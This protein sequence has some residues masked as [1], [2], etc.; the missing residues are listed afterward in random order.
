MAWLDKVIRPIIA[1]RQEAAKRIGLQLPDEVAEA[2]DKALDKMKDAT[3]E[4]KELN[5]FVAINVSN[6]LGFQQVEIPQKSIF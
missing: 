3:K 5:L 1:K 6:S 2:C 4:L